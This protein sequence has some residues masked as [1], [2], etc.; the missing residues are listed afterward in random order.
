M[1]RKIKKILLFPVIVFLFAVG[2][3]LYAIGDRRIS[4]EAV[5]K[6]TNDSSP[7]EDLIAE[8][9]DFETGLIEEYIE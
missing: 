5:L 6:K 3:F 4:N 7:K 2:W 8:G 9:S 1:Q